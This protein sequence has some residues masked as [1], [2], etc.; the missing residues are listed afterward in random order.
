MRKSTWTYSELTQI[1][2]KEIDALMAEARATAET[3]ERMR[4]RCYAAGVLMGWM[5][6]VAG[7]AAAIDTQRMKD[8]LRLTA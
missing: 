3:E 5:A 8:K 6:I 2:E 4:K 1:V 7:D